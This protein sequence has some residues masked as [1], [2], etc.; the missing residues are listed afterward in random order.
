MKEC[1]PDDGFRNISLDERTVFRY[2]MLGKTL[3]K[4]VFVIGIELR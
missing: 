4:K 1:P 2:P 3:A